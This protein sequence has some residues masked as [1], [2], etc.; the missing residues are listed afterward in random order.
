MAEDKR[1]RP[2]VTV[3][4][5]EFFCSGRERND[6]DTYIILKILMIYVIYTL[7]VYIYLYTFT[8]YTYI[9]YIMKVMFKS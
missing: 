4:R 2:I 6:I 7:Y 5:S 9:Y 3:G 1:R 8:L